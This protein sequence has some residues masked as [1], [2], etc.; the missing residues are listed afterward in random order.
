MTVGIMA[1]SSNK[2]YGILLTSAIIYLP[3]GDNYRAMAVYNSY[4][5]RRV[6][7]CSVKKRSRFWLTSGALV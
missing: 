2:R 7:S 3:S 4:P 6:Q 5:A 1:S